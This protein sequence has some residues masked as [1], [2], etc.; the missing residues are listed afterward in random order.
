LV[1]QRFVGS[2]KKLICFEKKVFRNPTE[3]LYTAYAFLGQVLSGGHKEGCRGGCGADMMLQTI[4]LLG[5]K[6]K[7][8]GSV[9]AIEDNKTP[10]LD[11]DGSE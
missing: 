9:L 3:I 4:R 1:L 10:A 2:S 8:W 11:D 6:A 7:T 5:K